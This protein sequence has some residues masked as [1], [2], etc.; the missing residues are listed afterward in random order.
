[1]KNSEEVI[2]SDKDIQQ[3]TKITGKI[4]ESITSLKAQDK[5]LK[6]LKDS[7]DKLS[8]SVTKFSDAAKSINSIGTSINKFV[9]QLSGFESKLGTIATRMAQSMDKMAESKLKASNTQMT[10]AV[11]TQKAKAA[12]P[13]KDEDVSTLLAIRN[14]YN[15][16][17]ERELFL[18]KSI[19]ATYASSKDKTAESA[20][21]ASKANKDIQV[22]IDGLREMIRLTDE[23]VSKITQ[24]DAAMSVSKRAGKASAMIEQSETNP[25]WK[26]TQDL[27]AEY[28]RIV[29]V[30]NEQFTILQRI[31]VLKEKIG[32]A[33]SEESKEL[34]E[35]VAKY[36]Q[37]ADANKAVAQDLGFDPNLAA[38]T[39]Q[40]KK[41]KKLQTKQ[42]ELESDTSTDAEM[43]LANAQ[44]AERNRLLKEEAAAKLAQQS[45]DKQRVDNMSEEQLKQRALI[46]EERQREEN[47]NSRISMQVKLKLTNEDLARVEN[48]LVEA[49]K[50]LNAAKAA[51]NSKAQINAIKAETNALKA[52]KVELA[53]AAKRQEDVIKGSKNM[54][55]DNTKAYYTTDQM[56]QVVRELPNFAISTRIGI[57]SLSNNL[58]Q[59]ATGF[60]TASRAGMTV[61]QMLKG[62]I[63]PMSLV[64][65]GVTALTIIM[66]NW[67]KIM[68]WLRNDFI[69]IG[70]ATEDVGEELRNMSGDASKSLKAFEDLRY[71]LNQFPENTQYLKEYN[72]TFGQ[73][74]G[75]A[76]D[77]AEAYDL[78]RINAD[79]YYEDVI[80]HEIANKIRLQAFEKLQEQLGDQMTTSWFDFD[81]SDEI[82]AKIKEFSDSYEPL[83]KM[84]KEGK[85]EFTIDTRGSNVGVFGVSDKEL[86]ALGVKLNRVF[87]KTKG[88][89]FVNFDNVS[90]ENM[91]KIKNKIR[92]AGQLGVKEAFSKFALSQKDTMDWGNM[93]AGMFDVDMSIYEKDAKGFGKAYSNKIKIAERTFKDL[94]KKEE[95]YNRRR[96]E[97]EIE[98]EY[99]QMAIRDDAYSSE[100]NNLEKRIAAYKQFYANKKQLFEI[101]RNLEIGKIEETREAELKAIDDRLESA[102]EQI[103]K[104]KERLAQFKEE[105]GEGKIGTII[106]NLKK[107]IADVDKLLAREQAKSK[108]NS[109]LITRYEERI[110][111]LNKVLTQQTENQKEVGNAIGYANANIEKSIENYKKLEASADEAREKVNTNA[112]LKEYKALDDFALS[113]V[114]N[115]KEE[116]ESYFDLYKNK[117][118]EEAQLAK[119]RYEKELAYIDN[120]MKERK[121]LLDSY[122]SGK[123]KGATSAEVLGKGLSSYER[124]EIVSIMGEYNNAWEEATSKYKALVTMNNSI[125]RSYEDVRDAVRDYGIETEI[126]SQSITD[127]SEKAGQAVYDSSL[128]AGLSEEQA[129]KKRVDIAQQ[130]FDRLTKLNEKG[131]LNKTSVNEE[132]EKLNKENLTAQQKHDEELLNIEAD[133]EAKLKK[134]ILDQSVELL[135]NLMKL[136]DA[137]M[138]RQFEM[139]KRDIDNWRQTQN[140]LL[141]DAIDSQVLTEKEGNAQKKA[142]DEEERKRRY[143]LAVD[144]FKYKQSMAIADIAISAAT[145]SIMTWVSSGGNAVLAAISQALIIAN[146]IASTA[147]VLSQPMPAYAEGTDFHKGG[148]ALVGDGGKSEGIIT[149]QGNIYKTPDTD[150]IVNMQ[151]GSKVVPDFDAF[152]FKQLRAG[153]KDISI[154][155]DN[156]RMMK[157][158]SQMNGHLKT[159]ARNTKYNK[160]NYNRLWVK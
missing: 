19:K 79:K 121:R 96:G 103:R 64:T 141:E 98:N 9:S 61:G 34:N 105:D 20:M 160:K 90:E 111:S 113:I 131:L 150:T 143:E 116:L 94:F 151:R 51:G 133:K 81:E 40:S 122:G 142:L 31:A 115:R 4:N 50:R 109:E 14:E 32:L 56:M 130:M 38:T 99:L 37:I 6:K 112:T 49:Q 147:I 144:E 24:L 93:M 137:V 71:S 13:N 124:P 41:S 23:E 86:E 29:A 119:A 153:N 127:W 18:Q 44:L 74:F 59:L 3:I 77:T 57:M 149:P 106:T 39:M 129:A 148:L 87:T 104:D 125:I 159:I 158:Q 135:Q 72:E 89:L 66:M 53:N 46:E 156:Q 84:M 92:D 73:T 118:D 28:K 22:R 60:M 35:L 145:A 95:Q 48:E 12:A 154:S 138:Q 15:Q 1:M 140:Q 102:R 157:S 136:T 75:L 107:E 16:A 110:L 91:V 76:K 10:Q 55:S 132:I 155:I 68:G 8:T 63:S 65:I 78:M 30:N 97:L 152:M 33:T 101:D 83:I 82:Q 43:A 85:K 21:S 52:Q 123:G 45:L 42:V 70:K 80:R 27:E 69:N 120:Y 47:L 58:P 88:T 108:P 11:T 7:Y 26:R 114:K 5:E 67:D 36:K 128:K 146:A 117:L 126:T 62:L 2:V 139:R 54:M 100:R 134:M 17:L 25:D